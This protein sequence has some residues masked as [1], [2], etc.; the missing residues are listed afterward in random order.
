MIECS[1]FQKTS[2]RQTSH[3]NRLSADE[4]TAGA[5]KSAII[6]LDSATMQVLS[7][8]FRSTPNL[9]DLGIIWLNVDFGPSRSS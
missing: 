2:L 7:L 1:E 3:F 9:G 5:A 4:A 6:V 8:I